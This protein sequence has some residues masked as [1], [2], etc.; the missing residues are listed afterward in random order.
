M[1]A[2]NVSGPLVTLEFGKGQ[3]ERA[4]TADAPAEVTDVGVK[5]GRGGKTFV[6]FTV[7]GGAAVED[8]T[9]AM[10]ACFAEGA[11]EVQLS[12]EKDVN[13]DG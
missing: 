10:L 12:K 1:R 6:T 9:L 3:F 8:V 2:V 7:G 5:A 11:D 4:S 13:R